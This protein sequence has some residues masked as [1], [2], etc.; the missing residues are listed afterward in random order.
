MPQEKLDQMLARQ[1]KQQAKKKRKQ[2][3]LDADKKVITVDE[4]LV[5]KE[6]PSMTQALE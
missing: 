5:L 1:K 4:K 6:P 2:R 3:F